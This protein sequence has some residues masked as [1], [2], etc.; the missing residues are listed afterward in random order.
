MAKRLP[1]GGEFLEAASFLP[2]PLR[3][4]EGDEAGIPTPFLIGERER[5]FLPLP[6]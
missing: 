5:V 2:L 6:P 4:G 3:G 1:V